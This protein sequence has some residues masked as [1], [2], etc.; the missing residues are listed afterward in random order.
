[1]AIITPNFNFD[2]KCEEAIYLY[3]KAF[4]AEIN[5][6]LRYSDAKWEDFHREL[7][8]EQKEYIYHAELLIGNQRIMMADNLDIPFKPSTALSLTVTLETKEDVKRVFEIMQDGSEIIY[9]VHSTTY[10]SC[11]VSFIDKFGFRWVIMT[12]QTEH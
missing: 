4:D 6:L 3:Q 11:S 9:P 5:C 10:S 1:M 12:D 8:E 2:G 7:S